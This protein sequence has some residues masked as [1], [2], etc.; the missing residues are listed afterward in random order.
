MSELS[1]QPSEGERVGDAI[2]AHLGRLKKAA[3]GIVTDYD[4]DT[5][6]CTVQI[7]AYDGDEA[8]KPLSGVPIKWPAGG[9]CAIKFGLEAGDEVLLI[10]ED[11]DPSRFRATGKA[12]Q[13]TL[14]RPHGYYA[15]AV[16]GKESDGSSGPPAGRIEVTGGTVVLAGAS[17]AVALASLV[18]TAIAN[19][20]IA[21]THVSAAPT[22]PTGPGVASGPVTPVGSTKVL[23]E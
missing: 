5:G 18:E 17:D 20:I 3:P 15:V 14:R 7:A 6:T 1:D 2:R 16:P 10:F 21:H 13:A 22:V 11:S 23:A 8:P 4:A 19:A 12:S 9:G